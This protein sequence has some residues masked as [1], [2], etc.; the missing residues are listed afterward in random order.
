MK[1]L[2]G[3]VLRNGGSVINAYDGIELK[4]TVS[5]EQMNDMLSKVRK[6]SYYFKWNNVKDGWGYPM[7]TTTYKRQIIDICVNVEKVDN[8]IAYITNS[9][10]TTIYNFK[11]DRIKS[12][13]ADIKN[14]NSLENYDPLDNEDI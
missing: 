3:Q 4:Q 14:S 12:F 13:L 1:D 7:I 6:A 2:I 5:L 9:N 10:G 11:A 8:L